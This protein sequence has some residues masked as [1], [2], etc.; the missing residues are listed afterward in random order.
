[1]HTRRAFLSAVTAAGG[2]RFAS[3][4][5]EIPRDLRITRIVGFDLV[6]RR[7]KVA[8]KNARLDVH[9]DRAVDRMVR[10]FTNT[11][12]EGLGNCRADSTALAKLLGKNPAEFFVRPQKR[13]AA[14]LGAGTMPL[15][16]LVGKLLKRPAYGLFFQDNRTIPDSRLVSI[17]DGSIYF[18][19]LLPQY[20]DRFE[21]RFKQEIDMGL[22]VGHRAFKVKIGRGHRWM[23]PEEGYERDLQVLRAIRRHAGADIVIGVDAN[24]GYD[25]A[26]AKRMLSD[27]PEFGFAFVEELFP[28]TIDECLALKRFIAEHQLPTLLADGE[29]QSRLEAFRPF[30]A[31][32]AIDVLQGDM[33][34]FGFEGILTK[35]EWARPQGILIAPHNWGSLVGFY[36]Q[37]HLG[38]A[39]SNFYLAEHDPLASDVLVAE[40]YTIRDGKIHVPEAPGFG[41]G[42][43]PA[44][45]ANAPIR[46]DLKA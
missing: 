38:L 9:G 3:W 22:A 25:L 34:H 46:F 15:W 10:I 42:V 29:T 6:C 12:V 17:Y 28:E 1:M 2:L 44:Q 37:L 33:N 31:A 27:L 7:A 20:A 35:A 14:P 39:I 45:F 23:P 32:R 13:M 26:R 24:N 16:D 5:E 21:D 4:A 36:M 43:D 8:G 11:G 41:L 40:G 18:A 19:D 30:I